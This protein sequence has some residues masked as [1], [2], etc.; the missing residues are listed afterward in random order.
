MYF[1]HLKKRQIPVSEED[2]PR[3]AR[4]M[5]SSH[6]DMIES[7]E[8]KTTKRGKQST[9]VEPFLQYRNTEFV[10]PLDIFIRQRKVIL[11]PEHDMST[12][13]RILGT[14]MVLQRN[15]ERHKILGIQTNS[16]TTRGVAERF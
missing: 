10:S 1:Y 13:V 3:E 4:R 5:T 7:K 6:L 9:N 15:Q 2:D 14:E 11:N 8:K 12:L 16:R